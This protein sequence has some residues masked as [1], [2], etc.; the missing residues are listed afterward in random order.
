MLKHRGSSHDE[1]E[2]R[3]S[4]LLTKETSRNFL[5]TFPKKCIIYKYKMAMVSPTHH[6]SRGKICVLYEEH[7]VFENFPHKNQAKSA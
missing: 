2:A 1:L 5:T 4:K 3:L 7:K 6:P